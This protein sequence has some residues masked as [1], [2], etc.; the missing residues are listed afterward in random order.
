VR[1]RAAW[2]VLLLAGACGERPTARPA[3]KAEPEEAVVR[4]PKDQ[5]RWVEFDHIFITYRDHERFGQVRSKEE[6]GRLARKVYEWARDGTDWDLLKDKYSDD[7]AKESGL[8][9]GPYIIVNDGLR[10]RTGQI[11][12]AQYAKRVGDLLFTME[13]GEIRLAEYHPEDC[14]FGWHI[15]KRL[16]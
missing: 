12:R 8:A 10:H 4:N 3:P 7:R 2:L 13:V 5:P 15:V 11:P 16:Q 6:A 1:R 14:Q 9:N